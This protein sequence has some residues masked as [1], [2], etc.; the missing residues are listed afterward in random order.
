MVASPRQQP[1]GKQAR[2]GGGGG[3]SVGDGSST[4][5]TRK[6]RSTKSAAPPRP[7]HAAHVILTQATEL[8][9]GKVVGRG[10]Q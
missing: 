1:R 4:A 6:E 2:G 3:G 9:F 10:T 8:V 5:R 7:Q